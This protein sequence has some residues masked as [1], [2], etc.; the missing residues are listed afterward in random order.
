MILKHPSEWEKIVANETNDKE[1]I[2]KMYKQLNTRKTNKPTKI[3]VEDLSRHFS[4]EDTQM[5]NTHMKRCSTC[6]IIR[7]TQTKITIRYHL[8]WSEWP[9]L[10]NL[11]TINAEQDVEKGDP[12]SLLVEI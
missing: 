7:E 6:L 2:S 8:T 5:A 3:W 12:H 10:K 11:Q 4:K 1:L 9:S